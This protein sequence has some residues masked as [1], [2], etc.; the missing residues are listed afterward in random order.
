MAFIG[1]LSGAQ[2][3]DRQFRA[4]REGLKETGYIEGRNIAV[5]YLSADGR[6]EQLPALA[7]ELVADAPGVIVAIAPPAALAAKAATATIPIVSAPTAISRAFTFCSLRLR[8]SGWDCCARWCRAA[9]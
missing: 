3:D 8:R 9:P 4:I 5:K 7:A 2:L 6:F 1:L